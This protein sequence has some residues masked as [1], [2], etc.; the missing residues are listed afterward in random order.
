MKK[1]ILILVLA[2]F[3]VIC[4][5][6]CRRDITWHDWFYNL[7]FRQWYWPLKLNRYD[8]GFGFCVWGGAND[9]Y[10]HEDM[11]LLVRYGLAMDSRGNVLAYDPTVHKPYLADPDIAANYNLTD[12]PPLFDPAVLNLDFSTADMVDFGAYGPLTWLSEAGGVSYIFQ[13]ILTDGR[14]L[15]IYADRLPEALHIE[16]PDPWKY[17]SINSAVVF[18]FFD[19]TCQVLYQRPGKWTESYTHISQLPGGYAYYDLARAEKLA[20]QEVDP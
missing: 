18:D 14:M 5:G 7:P 2:L 8:P 9:V 10:R 4:S 16:S 3:L 19:E 6:S 17:Y 12:T 15:K 13:F 1:R 20:K 11:V